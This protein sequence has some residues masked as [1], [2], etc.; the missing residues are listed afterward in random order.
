MI[1]FFP[2]EHVVNHQRRYT[3]ARYTRGLI[4]PIFG[5][6]VAASERRLLNWDFIRDFSFELVA[7]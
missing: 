5:D 4:A 2:T 7:L 1:D 3:H 6:V